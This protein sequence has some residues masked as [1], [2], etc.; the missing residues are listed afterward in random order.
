MSNEVVECCD[1]G[2][3]YKED[4][5]KR[6]VDPDNWIVVLRVCP[7]CDCPDFYMEDMED[8]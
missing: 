8:D 2:H 5:A 1:C 4:D 3:K 7:E 6:M